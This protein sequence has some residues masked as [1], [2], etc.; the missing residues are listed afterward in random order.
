MT[1]DERILYLQEMAQLQD[2]IR[3]RIAG[4]GAERRRFVSEQM[5]RP[6]IDDSRSFD[7]AVRG[8]IREKAEEVGFTFPER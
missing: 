4:L 3:D 6:G 2:E 5:A 1:P 8:T 7:R